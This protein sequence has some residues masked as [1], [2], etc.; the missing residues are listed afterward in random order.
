MHFLIDDILQLQ[1][2]GSPFL[3]TRSKPFYSQRHLGVNENEVWLSTGVGA[4]VTE[5]Q[6]S[7]LLAWPL[8]PPRCPMALVLSSP[9]TNKLHQS[10][11]HTHA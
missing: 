10:P 2:V 7:L 11:G 9:V 3:M 1:W 6:G 5:H 8:P 4:M